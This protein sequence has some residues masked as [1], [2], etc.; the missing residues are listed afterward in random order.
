MSNGAILQLESKNEFDEYLF[1][2][3]IKIQFIS[4]D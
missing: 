3:D 2:N 4:S 1:T